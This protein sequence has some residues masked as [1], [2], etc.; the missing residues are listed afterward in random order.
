VRR[1]AGNGV[2]RTSSLLYRGF[3]IRSG[4]NCSA[5]SRLEVGD[6]AGWKPALQKSRAELLYERGAVD[7]YAARAPQSARE[8]ARALP[9]MLTA[10]NLTVRLLVNPGGCP[11]ENPPLGWRVNISGR[12]SW[13]EATTKDSSSKNPI[14]PS[15][16]ESADWRGTTGNA[17]RAAAGFR[18]KSV[19]SKDESRDMGLQMNYEI[20]ESKLLNFFNNFFLTRLAAPA[21][22]KSGR[23][24]RGT[25]ALSVFTLAHSAYD[26][27][28]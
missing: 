27:T 9:R 3:L 15:Q 28:R 20:R 22:R 21:H 26:R 5:C 16:T 12:R 7:T 11:P 1:E 23:E 17:L 10:L 18:A 25:P 6:T 14:A 19:W 24:V 4:S 13:G 8:G 2:A